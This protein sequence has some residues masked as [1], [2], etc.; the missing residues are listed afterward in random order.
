M[1][2]IA[3][4]ALLAATLFAGAAAYISLVEH[5][6][7]LKLPDGPAVAQWEPSYARA[8]PIQSG[9]AIVGG[10]AGLAAWYLSK[11]WR[12]AAGSFLLLANWPFTLGV[13]M[14]VNKR[15]HAVK[16]EE[17]GPDSRRLL[18]RWGRLHNVRSLL[19]SASALVFAWAISA[20]MAAR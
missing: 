10:V 5:P 2:L 6:A 9:L 18:L 16:P 8:L 14:P 3:L 12:W 1:A 4:L 15:L 17:A 13:I 11:D 20:E 19:G 7:R